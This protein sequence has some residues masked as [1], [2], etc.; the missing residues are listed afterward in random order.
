MRPFLYTIAIVAAV[1]TGYA[2]ATLLQSTNSHLVRVHPDSLK[3]ECRVEWS[4][5]GR[6]PWPF[7]GGWLDGGLTMKC[8]EEV[9]PFG[10]IYVQCVCP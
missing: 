4:R 2:M 10:Q 5:E 1:V 9:E 7:G 8:G 6:G 3:N